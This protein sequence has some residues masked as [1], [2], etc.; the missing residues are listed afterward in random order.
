[1]RFSRLSLWFVAALLASGNQSAVRAQSET[2]PT[3]Q[4]VDQ[5][6]DRPKLIYSPSAPFPNDAMRR[7]KPEGKVTLRVVVDAEGRI[8]GAKPLTGPPEF[9]QAAIKYVEQWQYE[10]PA[11]A[12]VTITVG[13][14]WGFPK[15]CPGPISE[16]GGVEGSGRLVDKNGK[17]VAVVDNDDYPLPPYPVEERMAGAVGKMVLSVTLKRDGRVKEIHAVTSLSPGLDKAAIDMVRSWKFKG[18]QDAPLCNDGNFKA[19]LKDLRVQFVFHAM[20]HPC[21]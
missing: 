19:H 21:F 17:L 18:C 10:P 3:N 15:E 7:R 5:Q 4:E 8:S 13:M 2:L 11:H 12:P 6:D 1:M 16:M 14:A 20:C 9:Y